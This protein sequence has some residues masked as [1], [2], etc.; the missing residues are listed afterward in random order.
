MPGRSAPEANRDAATAE[1][2]GERLDPAT[3]RGGVSVAGY[4]RGYSGMVSRVS[5]RLLS[6]TTMRSRK[7]RAPA[8]VTSASR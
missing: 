5:M 2:C 7:R 3:G 4:G 8:S 6:Q 1:P